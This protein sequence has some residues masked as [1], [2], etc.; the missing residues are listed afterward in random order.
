M[1]ARVLPACY[2][3]TDVVPEP[4]QPLH[5]PQP[6]QPP[7]QPQEPQ[8][9]QEPQE[10]VA[11]TVPDLRNAPDAL[12]WAKAQREQDEL[13][14]IHQLHTLADLAW[15]QTTI[16][17][18]PAWL[19]LCLFWL[20]AVLQFAALVVAG[21]ACSL[22]TDPVVKGTS[23]EV[24]HNNDVPSDYHF[25]SFLFMLYFSILITKDAID[26]SYP[27]YN[28]LTEITDGGKFW[29]ACVS[30]GFF[31]HSNLGHCDFCELFGWHG[32]GSWPHGR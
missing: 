1:T 7:Q 11:E 17:G 16:R 15:G 21:R 6:P 32:P 22:L 14:G 12:T 18:A 27:F 3:R 31:F 19:P 28:L 26:R 9:P 13:Q 29:Q 5:L 2:G 24:G 8:V 30:I 4:P 10:L 23:N 20:V 25:M